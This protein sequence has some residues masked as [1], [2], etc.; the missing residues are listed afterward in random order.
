MSSPPSSPVAKSA[1]VVPATVSKR[2]SNAD[3]APNAK[4][5]KGKGKALFSSSHD[6]ASRFNG[7]VARHDVVG[8]VAGERTPPN[9]RT[10]AHTPHTHPTHPFPYDGQLVAQD[11]GLATQLPQVIGH[12]HVLRGFHQDLVAARAMLP[13]P[14]AGW[15][16]KGGNYC[17]RCQRSGHWEGKC[18]FTKAQADA[19][20]VNHTAEFDSVCGGCKQAIKTGVCKVTKPPDTAWWHQKCYNEKLARA[21]AREKQAGRNTFTETEEEREIIRFIDENPK[22]SL[23]VEAVAGAGKVR[24]MPLTPP[25]PPRPPPPR[26]PRPP[27][28][29]PPP[30]P[31]PPLFTRLNES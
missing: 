27:R 20:R 19:S 6:E 28:P 17:F 9:T 26:P 10:H 22:R 31:P 11:C 1:P 7:R 30:P 2:R 13:K 24:T 4:R 5:F 23:V 14:M 18:P 21:I 15:V 3:E 16:V 8:R 25:P 29:P 12:S